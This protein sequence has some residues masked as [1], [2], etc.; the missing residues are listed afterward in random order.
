MPEYEMND[1]YNN[2]LR[3]IAQSP[4]DRRTG[5]FITNPLLGSLRVA[6]KSMVQST[7]DTLP[8]TGRT[9]SK[10]FLQAVPHPGTLVAVKGMTATVSAKRLPCNG[11][12]RPTSFNVVFYPVRRDDGGISVTVVYDPMSNP[13]AVSRV[14][15]NTEPGAFPFVITVEL[16]N[17]SFKEAQRLL[18]HFKLVLAVLV[19]DNCHWVILDSSRRFLRAVGSYELFY[20]D[21]LFRAGEGSLLSVDTARGQPNTILAES[22][23]DGQW[24][25]VIHTQGGH[26]VTLCI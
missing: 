19:R 23:V 3:A 4:V 26:E 24:S 1:F 22:A 5:T 7:V 6:L 25:F 14:H 16:N 8:P 20:A 15:K 18:E 2:L 21:C 9:L 10:P 12:S 13:Q 17:D 11:V